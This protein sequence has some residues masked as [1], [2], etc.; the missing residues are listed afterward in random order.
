MIPRWAGNLTLV[1]GHA[2]GIT[3]AGTLTVG[4]NLFATTDAN[5]GVINLGGLD[6]SATTSKILQLT[7]HHNNGAATV[8]N[9]KTPAFYICCD[10]GGNECFEV[11]HPVTQPSLIR[12]LYLQM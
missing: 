12:I 6:M 5:N 8:V 3:D 10:V 4:G 7:T 11:Q 2:S 1:S 9:T